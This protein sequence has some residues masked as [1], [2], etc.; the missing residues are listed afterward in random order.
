MGDWRSGQKPEEARGEMGFEG[1]AD[2]R[3]RMVRR[4][5]SVIVYIVVDGG[6]GLVVWVKWDGLGFE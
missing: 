6:W 2:V 5:V 1:R 3:P 4:V